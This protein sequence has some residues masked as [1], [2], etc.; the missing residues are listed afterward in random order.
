MTSTTADKIWAM[1]WHQFGQTVQRQ[2][3]RRTLTLAVSCIKRIILFLVNTDQKKEEFHNLLEQNL[4]Q[5]ANSYNKI[6]LGDFNAKVGKENIYKPTTGNE[7][8]HNETNNNGIKMIQFAVSKGL[9]V[10]STTFPHKDIHKE[11]W[12]SETVGQRIK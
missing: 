9:N 6:I 12:Y 4:N 7:S 2:L 8:L 5:I 11:T 10:T 1:F 3:P